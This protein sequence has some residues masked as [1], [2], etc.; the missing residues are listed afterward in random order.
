MET[1]EK[2]LY[3]LKKERS[4]ISE[5]IHNLEIKELEEKNAS[6]VG[7]YFKKENRYSQEVGGTWF[8]YR[9]VERLEGGR[10]HGLQ[11]QTDCYGR[12][13]IEPDTNLF[14]FD[15]SEQIDQIEFNQAY[16]AMFTTVQGLY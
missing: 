6:L 12:I 14:S 15:G 1:K 2:T 9:Y 7:C 11:F 3:Q 16:A 5:Q 10:P 13:E 4:A 8:I